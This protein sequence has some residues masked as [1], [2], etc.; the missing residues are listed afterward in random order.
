MNGKDQVKAMARDLH[1]SQSQ[2]TGS[3][4]VYSCHVHFSENPKSPSLLDKLDETLF[5][6]LDLRESLKLL[7]TLPGGVG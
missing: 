7:C 3:A 6:R 2:Q 1:L 5:G 4:M